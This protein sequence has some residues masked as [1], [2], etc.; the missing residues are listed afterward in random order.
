MTS[1]MSTASKIRCALSPPSY[2]IPIVDASIRYRLPQRYG[3]L[4][5][6]AK[7]LFDKEFQFQDLDPG[8]PRIFPTR[9]ILFRF[10]LAL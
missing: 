6:E 4:S 9:L 8:N 7:N 2:R 3:I 1:R 5:L 10:T